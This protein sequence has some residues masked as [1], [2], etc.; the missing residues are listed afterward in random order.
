MRILIISLLW[1]TLGGLSQ[2]WAFSQNQISEVYHV[3]FVQGTI[4]N[5]TQNQAVTRGMRL[6]AN[7]KIAFK[8]LNAKAVLLSNQKGRFTIA[9]SAKTKGS[10]MAAFL[11][12]VLLP[13]KQNANLSTRALASETVEDLKSYLGEDSFWIIGDHL[14]IKLSSS[15]YELNE[16][17]LLVIR[18]QFEGAVVNKKIPF[19]GNTI[20]LD[21]N[22]LFKTKDGKTISPNEVEHIA[23]YRY[24][25]DSKS[26]E[27]ILE[28]KINFIDQAEL[29]QVLTDLRQSEETENLQGEELQQYLISFCEDS[30]GKTD[31]PLLQAWL[32]KNN[33]K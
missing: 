21:K 28:C 7:D 33:F 6:N 25:V 18:Y 15:R 20:L 29:K 19:E 11:N 4:L 9:P 23:L 1:V 5:V 26:S 12:E 17:R 2:G 22:L 16:N 24:Y 13:V 32:D 14:K 27:K 8:S 31:R 30:F 3:L 10:E